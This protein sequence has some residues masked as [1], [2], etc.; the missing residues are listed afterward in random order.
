MAG[1]RV[2]TALIDL[3]GT[4]HVEDEAIPGAIEA[5][6]RLR[7]SG[8]NVK[9]ATNTTKESR[10]LLCQRLQTIG[11][12]I[13]EN[14]IFTSLTAAR[15]YVVN[16]HL[17]PYLL[18][19]DAAVEDFESYFPTDMSPEDADAVLVGLAPLKFDFQHMNNAAA[20]LLRGSPLIAIHKGRYFKTKTGLS[21]G[22]GPFVSA[23]EL[24]TDCEAVVVGKPNGSFFLQAIH[25]FGSD[26]AQCVVVGDDVRDD[27]LGA[28]SAGLQGILVQTGK[29]R[30]GDEKSV[31][32]MTDAASNK[33]TVPDNLCPSIVQAVDLILK[34]MV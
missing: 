12:D 15:D 24:A 2:S 10:R 8:I 25:E 9:F 4:I 23:L 26:P 5:I 19:D 18:V 20:V 3:S 14:E 27:V 30:K 13:R 32:P 28:Q 11:F 7:S 1:R 17:K 29:Y 22:P 31:K 6:R 16:R 33:Q 21:L 34:E